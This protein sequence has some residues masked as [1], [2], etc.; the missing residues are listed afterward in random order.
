MV[1]WRLNMPLRQRLG[2]IIL[3]SVSLF[4]MVMSIL[5]TIGLK[6]IADQQSDPTATDVQYNATLSI[7]WTCLEQACV[8]IM[9]CVP[10]LRAVMKLQLARSVSSSLA[11]LLRR[12]KTSPSSSSPSFGRYYKTHNSEG[13]DAEPG[14]LEM[15]TDK[16]GRVG[17]NMGRP[18]AV[19]T[20]GSRGESQ[21][22]LIKG[23][24]IFQTR[25]LNVS[26][27][28]RSLGPDM[29]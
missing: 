29:V 23:R 17:G 1:V 14:G 3:L 26:Y 9:G 4:T 25:E 20:A 6:A 11:S 10:S 28:N 12:P 7:L 15:R 13:S 21:R 18:Y 8:I 5:K 24:D 22:D 27:S 19:A 16:L 2:L